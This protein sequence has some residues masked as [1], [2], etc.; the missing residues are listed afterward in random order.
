MTPDGLLAETNRDPKSFQRLIV[1]YIEHR[2]PEVSG[3]TINITVASLKHFFA[4]NDAGEAINWT[5]VSKLAR[6]RERPEATGRRP[7]RR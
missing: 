6:G 1:D 5:R 3:G 7:Q 4:M 2:K